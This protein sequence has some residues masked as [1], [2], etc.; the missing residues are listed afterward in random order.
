MNTQIIHYA[1]ERRERLYPPFLGHNEFPRYRGVPRFVFIWER[2]EHKGRPAGGRN[3]RILYRGSQRKDGAGS[4]R[5]E[6]SQVKPIR[7]TPAEASLEGS[8]EPYGR[9]KAKKGSTRKNTVKKLRPHATKNVALK[10]SYWRAI[11]VRQRINREINLENN[12]P[13]NIKCTKQ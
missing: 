6:T 7:S 13:Q 9:M 5:A 10:Y 4:S 3:M 2:R 11:Q 12:T 8:A 1:R